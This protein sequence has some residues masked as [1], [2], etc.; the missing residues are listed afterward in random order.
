M[1]SARIYTLKPASVRHFV[2]VA[3]RLSTDPSAYE[4]I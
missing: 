3:G 4:E 2:L 1:P